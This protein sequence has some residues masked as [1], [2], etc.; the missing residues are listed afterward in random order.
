MSCHEID[1][2]RHKHCTLPLMVRQAQSQGH[3]ITNWCKKSKEWKSIKTCS[4][5]CRCTI[6]NRTTEKYNNIYNKP[7]KYRHFRY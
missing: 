1:R 2:W 6:P 3:L 5:E 7:F 4:D